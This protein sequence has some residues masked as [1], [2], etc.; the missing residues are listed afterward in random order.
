MLDRPLCGQQ[1][2]FK[3]TNDQSLS[4]YRPP[5]YEV[6]LDQGV[7]SETGHADAG[8]SRQPAFREVASVGLVHHRIVLLEAREIDTRHHDMLEAEFE[9]GQS[10]RRFSMTARVCAT[11]PSGN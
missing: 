5:A 4:S 1:R 6:D 11:M 7:V 2:T 10:R 9:T 8:A 3:T